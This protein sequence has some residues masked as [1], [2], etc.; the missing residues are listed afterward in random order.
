MNCQAR[1]SKRSFFKIIEK[2]EKAAFA[3]DCLVNIE[4]GSALSP[5]P[6]I[7]AGLK[8]LQE[9]LEEPAL[10]VDEGVVKNG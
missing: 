9:K 2:A 5:P 10:V 6:Y 7:Q 1:N 3:I 4:D 8:W